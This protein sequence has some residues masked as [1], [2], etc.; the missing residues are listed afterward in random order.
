MGTC[1]SNTKLKIKQRNLLKSKK[2]KKINFNKKKNITNSFSTSSTKTSSNPTKNQ[3]KLSKKPSSDFILPLNLAIYDDLTKFYTISNEIIG[4]GA[5]GIVSIGENSAGK[6]AIKRINKLKIKYPEEIIKEAEF[7]KKLNHKNIIKYYGVFEDLKYISFIM[8]LGE[9]GD[10]FDFIVNSP[11]GH[12]PLDITIELTE[13]ILSILVYLHYEIKIIHRDLKPENFLITIDDNN[14]IQIKLIDFGMSTFYVKGKKLYEYLGTPNYAA[15][16]IVL[17]DGYNEKVDIWAMGVILFNML[18]GFEPFKGKNEVELENEI[19]CKEIDFELI[20]NED[21]RNLC[22]KMLI[23]V[24][25]ERINAKDA[26]D[27]IKKI[28]KDRE[29]VYNEELKKMEGDKDKDDINDNLNNKKERVE[30]NAFI[31][32]LNTRFNFY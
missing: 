3:N 21:M 2:S 24:E 18:T 27:M 32:A 10:L 1:D 6:F 30:Y 28:K 25:Y 29:R 23:R 5:S 20:E 19:K 26:Y 7:A 4:S 14:N 11:I 9:G 8:E 13:Q 22:K 31:D 12:L 16:E 15:P 17:E